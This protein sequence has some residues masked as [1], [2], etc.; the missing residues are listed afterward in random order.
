MRF[1]A[2]FARFEN[3]ED[4]PDSSSGNYTQRGSRM[5]NAEDATSA[6]TAVGSQTA[7][8]GGTADIIGP[9]TEQVPF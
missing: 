5:N 2:S 9:S 6:A 7:F 3:W 1:R 4:A 8:T